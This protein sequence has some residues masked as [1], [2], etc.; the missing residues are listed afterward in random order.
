MSEFTVTVLR[1]ALFGLLWLF[2]F[3]I[4]GVLRQDLFG[5]RV[6]RNRSA[7][8]KGRAAA[9]AP[10]AAAVSAGSQQ[11]PGGY[12][13]PSGGHRPAPTLVLTSGAQAGMS[14][15]LGTGQLT[16]GRAED[17]GLIIDDDYASSRHARVYPQ[18]GSWVLEDTNSTNGTYVHGSR[19]TG[20]VRLDPGSRFTIGSTTME[21]RA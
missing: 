18:A 2:V 5:P 10:V 13:A 19:I 8:R 15:M 9:E 3:L 12:A 4:A 14:L 7:R 16:I 11:P 1:F 20:P 6:P 17:C 21:L